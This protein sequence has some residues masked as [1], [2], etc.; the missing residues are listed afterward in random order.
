MTSRGTKYWS[1]AAIPLIA[2]EL[3]GDIIAT[4]ADLA[5]VTTTEG[6][7]LSVLV[8]PGHRSF[9]RLEHWEGHDLREFL[10]RESIPKLN[11]QLGLFASGSDTLKAV[12]LNH[13]DSS[14]SWEFPIRY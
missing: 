2:R 9:G 6:L 5:V 1:G 3:L 8:N 11:A 4:A 10:T 12:E 13:S 14:M 7:V